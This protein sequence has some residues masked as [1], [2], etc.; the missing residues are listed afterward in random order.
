MIDVDFTGQIGVI[1]RTCTDGCKRIGK[2][3]LGNSGIFKCRITDVVHLIALDL[4]KVRTV[5]ECVRAEHICI[6]RG[7]IIRVLNAKINRGQI[8]VACKCVVF[9]DGDLNMVIGRHF[10]CAVGF[11]FGILD[12]TCED[13]HIIFGS[14]RI[15][16]QYAFM[17]LIN[18]VVICNNLAQL[19]GVS[20]G[21]IP[22][23]RS[24]FC[25]TFT[26]KLAEC[27]GLNRLV[28]KE[29]ISVEADNSIYVTVIGNEI[30]DD[31]ILFVCTTSIG[32]AFRICGF[33]T[34]DCSIVFQINGIIDI[35]GI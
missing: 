25:L 30:V 17:C 13:G 19:V 32:R 21:A 34:Y 28:T 6:C 24:L 8:L 4:D 12:Q 35:V 9:N 18:S 15:A 11:S 7:G 5:V 26:D 27:N 22:D 3:K 31:Y 14:Q 1:E 29:C 10:V 23:C 2:R 20:E 16:K 33:F